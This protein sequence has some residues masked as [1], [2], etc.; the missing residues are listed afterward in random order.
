MTLARKVSYVLFAAIVFAIAGLRL[1]DIALAGLFSYMILDLTHRRVSAHTAKPYARWVS[2]FIFLVVAAVLAYLF[3]R[4][5]RQALSMIPRIV[6]TAIPRLDALATRVGIDLPFGN[7]QE[8][9]DLLMAEIKEN[10]RS[11]THESGLLTKGFFQIIVAVFIAV[12]C[13][14]SGGRTPERLRGNLFDAVR[15]E[16]DSRM[17]VFM[18]GFEKVLGAQFMVAS[19]NAFLTGIFLVF[20]DIPYF[21]F[22]I[23]TTFIF[24]M[25]PIVGNVLSNSIIVGTALTVSP[26]LAAIS[27]VFLMIIHKLQYLLYSRIIGS[28]IDTPV[29]QILIGV[30]VGEALIGVPGIILAPAM[31]HYLREEMQAIEYKMQ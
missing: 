18:E 5:V 3:S 1:A 30:L 28:S 4:F 16:F 6:G 9:R 12:L 19:I 8:L 25:L 29:W 15:L 10:A 26:R 31:L 23:L 7:G 21:L 2:L 14:M 13:F 27:L 17:R 11:I 24:G 22:L 20:M